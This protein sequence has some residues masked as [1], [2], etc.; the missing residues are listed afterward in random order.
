MHRLCSSPSGSCTMLYGNVVNAVWN[1]TGLRCFH[2]PLPSFVFFAGDASRLIKCV[3]FGFTWPRYIEFAWHKVWA[4]TNRKTAIKAIRMK[5]KIK[6]R[7]YI[8]NG[9]EFF[10][11]STCLVTQ[12]TWRSLGSR[13]HKST[14]TSHVSAD[15][16]GFSTKKIPQIRG[17]WFI[18]EFLVLFSKRPALSR[19]IARQRFNLPRLTYFYAIATNF[20][21]KNKSRETLDVALSQRK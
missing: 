17:T 2:T 1:R 20:K 12:P 9:N 5:S 10:H 21:K 19:L 15:Y 16:R 14:A 13:L 3:C 11:S 6:T 8:C 18:H 4:K 7:I